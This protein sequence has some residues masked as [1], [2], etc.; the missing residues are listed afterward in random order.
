[1]SV[2][3][4]RVGRRTSQHTLHDELMGPRNQRQA[5]VVVESL[6]DVLPEGVA[7]ATRGDAPST[8]VVRIRPEEITHRTLMWDL[9]HPVD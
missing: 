9:L 7:C 8:T 4:D 3:A 1:M 6:R 2:R 5:I